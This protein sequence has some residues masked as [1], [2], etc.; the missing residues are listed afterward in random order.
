MKVCI[1]Q[2]FLDNSTK[3]PQAVAR[4]FDSTD[5][6]EYFGPMWDN[7]D[8][9]DGVTESRERLCEPVNGTG[10]DNFTVSLYSIFLFAWTFTMI[11][12][13]HLVGKR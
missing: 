3:T 1:D 8:S 9:N 12:P 7:I 2:P 10:L 11:L 6:S 13:S 5:S 4:G